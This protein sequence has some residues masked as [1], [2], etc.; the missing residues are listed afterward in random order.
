[1]DLTWALHQEQPFGAALAAEAG[2][3]LVCWQHQ[4]LPELA[5]AIAAPQ[6]LPGLAEGWSW[7]EDRY[8]VIWSLRR[9]GPGKAWRFAQHCQ[10]LLPG[11]PDRPFGLTGAA[12]SG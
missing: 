5:R 10:G 1:M 11:D 12:G 6:P 7:P 3:A 8:D 2:V 9:G 4:G